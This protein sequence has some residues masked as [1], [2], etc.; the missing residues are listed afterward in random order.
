MTEKQIES[1]TPI[2]SLIIFTVLANFYPVSTIA[3]LLT[4]LCL[5]IK[6]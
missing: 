5:K 2:F 6:K 3:F 1:L 4:D